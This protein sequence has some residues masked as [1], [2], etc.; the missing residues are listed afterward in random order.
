MIIRTHVNI[1]M[2]LGAVRVVSRLNVQVEGSRL[3]NGDGQRRV[4]HAII[5]TGHTSIVAGHS[6]LRS[7]FFILFIVYKCRTTRI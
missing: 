5:V 2:I 7:V 6:L 4:G 1:F 3:H